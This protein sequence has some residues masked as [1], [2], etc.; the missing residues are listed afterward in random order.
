[1]CMTCVGDE[2]GVAISQI[3]DF[4]GLYSLI[5]DFLGLYSLIP[6]FYITYFILH[7]KGL[8]MTEQFCSHTILFQGTMYIV[9]FNVF[10]KIKF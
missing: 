1:M 2:S 5:P 7:Y 6:D 3:P 10:L 8:Y 4:L 9:V